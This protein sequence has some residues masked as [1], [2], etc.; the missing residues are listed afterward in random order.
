VFALQ[1]TNLGPLPIHRPTGEQQ[2][3]VKEREYAS[4]CASHLEWLLY[5]FHF[6]ATLVCLLV[7][8]P[9]RLYTGLTALAL[10]PPHASYLDA[11]QR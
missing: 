3:T 2:S 9:C 7:Q 10:W 8:V 6:T 4:A 11:T 5:H 1:G